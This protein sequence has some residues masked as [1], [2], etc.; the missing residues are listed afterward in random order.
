MERRDFL[1]LTAASGLLVAVDALPARAS[2]AKALPPDAVGLLYDATLCIGCK[3]C[4][5]NC[6]KFNTPEPGALAR[7]GRST[8]PY[9][10]A[11]AGI[12][13]EPRDLS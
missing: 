10:T 1:K 5:V 2:E 4:M 6:K 11:G 3:S 9:E 7:K 13:D 12:W 8:P